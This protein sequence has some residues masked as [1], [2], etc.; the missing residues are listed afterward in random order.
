MVV[1]SIVSFLHFVAAFGI[2]SAVVFQWMTF[3]RTP[4]VIEA[5]RIQLSDRW[6]GIF[7]GLILIV[8]FLRVYYFEKGSEFYFSSPFFLIKLGLFLVIG[9]L[10]IYPTVKYLSWRKHTAQKQPPAMSDKEFS[11]IALI[12]KLELGLLFALMLSASLMA[13]GVLH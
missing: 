10:S 7:A 3:S 11:T 6:F 4:S 2:V 1:N 8:G 5:Q 13:K 9:L 12:L